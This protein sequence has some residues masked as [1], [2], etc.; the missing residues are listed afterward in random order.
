MVFP[1]VSRRGA[2]YA[3]VTTIVLSLITV[4]ATGLW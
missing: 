2:C 3:P 1:T 4:I